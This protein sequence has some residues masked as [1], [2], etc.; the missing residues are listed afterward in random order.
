[1]LSYPKNRNIHRPLHLY[2]PE[3]S[4]YFISCR[5]YKGVHYFDS[6]TRKEVL[7]K[8]I[9]DKAKIF[10]IFFFGWAVLNNHYHLLLK[11]DNGTDLIKL[12]SQVNGKSSYLFNKFENI[13]GRKIW[14]QYRD[15]I[16]RDEKD[17]Y[18]HLNYIHQNPIKHGLVKNFD[19]LANYKFCS[20]KDYL[21][22]LGRDWLDDCFE[23][24]P[25]INYINE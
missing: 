19:E 25:V 24:Y 17:F 13:K 21:K 23:N 5:T 10:K 7:S 1:M 18:I 9:F 11:A 6:E 20:Y 14:F 4:C 12:I 3:T 8:I 15:K 2:L 16:I 22:E